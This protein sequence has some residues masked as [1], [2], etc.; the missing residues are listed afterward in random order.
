MNYFRFLV[1]LLMFNYAF[2]VNMSSFIRTSTYTG[3][4][5]VHVNSNSLKI[6]SGIQYYPPSSTLLDVLRSAVKDTT[7]FLFPRKVYVTYFRSQYID[8]VTS[9]D[10]LTD[11][12]DPINILLGNELGRTNNIKVTPGMCITIPEQ[13]RYI[14]VKGEVIGNIV[15]LNGSW[16]SS[17][18]S[19][20]RLGY[21]HYR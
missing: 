18:N 17:H 21:P 15:T 4:V 12:I 8:S 19:K 1:I 2:A 10:V 14:F 7:E 11:T 6:L 5:V 9:S 16:S 20:S 13:M 3:E